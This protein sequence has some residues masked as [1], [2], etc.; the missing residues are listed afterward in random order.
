MLLYHFNFFVNN[1]FIGKLIKT[2][3]SFNKK[4]NG[5]IKK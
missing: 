3:D 1:N 4:N 5:L 2:R